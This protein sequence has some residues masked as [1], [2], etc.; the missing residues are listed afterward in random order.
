LT[1]LHRCLGPLLVGVQARRLTTLLEAVAATMGGPR[2]MLTD[3]GRRLPVG[4]QS[5]LV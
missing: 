5:D 3:T 1:V 2:P 4:A